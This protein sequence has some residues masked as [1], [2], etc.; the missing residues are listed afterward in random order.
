MIIQKVILILNNSIVAKPKIESIIYNMKKVMN[1]SSNNLNKILE[2]NYKNIKKYNWENNVKLF[3]ESYCK[4]YY[5]VKQKPLVIKPKICIISNINNSCGIGQYTINLFEHYNNDIIY[6]T[7]FNQNNEI[8]SRYS[9]IDCW[10]CNNSNNNNSYNNLIN[11]CEKHD[12]IIIQYNFGFFNYKNLEELIIKLKKM[13]KIIIIEL[14]SVIEYCMSS[15]NNNIEYNKGKKLPNN[16][17]LG[18]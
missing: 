17:N 7:P 9:K 13:K 18:R 5:K 15:C 11:Q 14:H 1:M 8:Q 10:E 4:Y 2:I 6:L 3:L 12:I 16:L